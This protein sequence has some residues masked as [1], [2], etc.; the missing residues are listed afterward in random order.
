[1]PSPTIQLYVSFSSAPSLV[2]RQL[3]NINTLQ[4][5]EFY[6]PWCGHCQNLKPAY[7]KAAKNLEGLAKVAAVNCDEDSNKPFC[8]TMGI[9]GFPTLKIVRPGLKKGS[10]PVVEDYNGPRSAS[11][12]VEAVVDKINNHVKR[13][14]DKDFDS[15]LSENP[16]A[17]K[18]ILFTEKGTTSALL[19]SIA[20]DF[21]GV[22]SVGQ[23]RNTA[24]KAVETFGVEK[25]PTLVLLPGEGKDSI[26]YDG[27][28]KKEAMVKFLSQAGSPNPDPSTAKPKKEKAS[29]QPSSAKTKTKTSTSTE[30]AEPSSEPETQG[31]EQAEDPTIQKPIILDVAPPIPIINTPEK[32]VKEC[33]SPKS[34]TCVLAF[35][36]SGH[37]EQAEKALSSLAELAF[38]HAQSKRHLFPFFEVHVEDAHAK[39]ILQALDLKEDVQ[40]LAVNARRNWWRHLEG[41]DFGHEAI[42]SWIDQIR[43][44]EGTK[45]KLP[46]GIVAAAAV[47]EETIF[48]ATPEATSEPTPEAT[49]ESSTIVETEAPEVTPEAESESSSTETST[50]QSGADPVPDAKT[51]DEHDE[52]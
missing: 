10:K 38:K 43:M 50:P 13:L 36:P 51:G 3:A 39:E 52:L 19:K 7:E 30:S 23:V 15:F 49:E 17:P 9:K 28:L 5:V 29:S 1:M 27:E 35:V 22:I 48:E 6:A 8:G 25:Y 20:I 26:V 34:H 40:I 18:A 16:E 42:E 47:E 33:L 12:I 11:G 44:S 2:H 24:T 14:S 21:L 41:T 37:G 32:L 4:I 31:T 46:E 45:K